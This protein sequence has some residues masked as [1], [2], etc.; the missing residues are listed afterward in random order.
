MVR[1]LGLGIHLQKILV[2]FQEDAWEVFHVAGA[3]HHLRGQA[4][5]LE[6]AQDV[7]QLV[8]VDVAVS[9][10][11]ALP[12]QH[13]QKGPFLLH[14]H[15]ACLF[16]H[17]EDALR[18]QAARLHVVHVEAVE[19]L[20]QFA[21]FRRIEAAVLRVLHPVEPAHLQDH[22][23]QLEGHAPDA[24]A[25]LRGRLAEHD[26]QHVVVHVQPKRL[27]RGKQVRLGVQHAEVERNPG[28]ERGQVH[29]G[30]GEPLGAVGRALPL[31]R[32]QLRDVVRDKKV[33]DQ[34][35]LEAVEKRLEL[36]PNLQVRVVRGLRLSGQRNAL[37]PRHGLVRGYAER[38]LKHADDVVGP[39]QLRL[40]QGGVGELAH[41]LVLGLRF[42][43]VARSGR[44]R[45]L[46]ARGPTLGL[47][48]LLLLFLLRWLLHAPGLLHE[49]CLR[50]LHLPL[51]HVFQR[52]AASADSVLAVIHP[53]EGNAFSRL[54]LLAF[55]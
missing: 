51:N 22:A 14:Q 12:V 19:D 3:L 1:R 50:L 46:L 23:G 2:F 31:Q 13:A 17:V 41:L 7:Q 29:P 49:P 5:V 6:P 43:V 54:G 18:A 28:R 30:V 21:G 10:L 8:E 11:V 44:G 15:E 42:G 25:D 39:H 45:L 16:Q 37:P 48:L 47:L 36:V 35:Q 38:V 53:R 24:G 9:V 27:V 26:P 32:V 33:R 40:Q 55:R 52:L 34:V 4:L 20:V